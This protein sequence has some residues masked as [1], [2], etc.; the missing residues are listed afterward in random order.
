VLIILLKQN[1][2]LGPD[3]DYN[4]ALILIINTFVALALCAYAIGTTP[5]NEG[6]EHACMHAQACLNARMT[7][8]HM[9]YFHDF[10]Y[11]TK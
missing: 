11:K 5:I 8:K 1:I 3:I 9:R 10:F 6:Y 2:N 7:T 4:D